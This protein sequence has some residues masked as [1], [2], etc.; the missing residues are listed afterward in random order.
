VNASRR[1]PFADCEFDAVTCIDAINHLPDR[2][3]VVTEWRRVL[4]PLGRLLFTDP[5]TMTG[6]V[7]K[8]EIAVRSSAGFF[9]FVPADY[10]RRVLEECGMRLLVCEDVTENM[11]QMARRRHLARASREEALRKI[12]GN[13]NYEQQQDFLEVAAR[14]AREHR[15]SRFLYVAEKPA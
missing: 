2:P 8:D 9:L 1:L 5:I 4:K 6:P 3:A 15:L 10:D 11:T 14:I 13:A 12:E 7:S